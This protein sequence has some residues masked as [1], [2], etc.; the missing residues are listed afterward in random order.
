MTCCLVSLSMRAAE[1]N[2]D[3]TLSCCG[4]ASMPELVVYVNNFSLVRQQVTASARVHRCCSG[5]YW[6]DKFEVV[7]W[8]YVRGT[9]FVKARKLGQLD[10]TWR[11]PVFERPSWCASVQWPC[12]ELVLTA[13]VVCSGMCHRISSRRCSVSMWR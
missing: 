7:N 10:G 6:V 2:R 9:D 12:D 3:F 5:S 1:D 8:P 13:A 11:P 4:M